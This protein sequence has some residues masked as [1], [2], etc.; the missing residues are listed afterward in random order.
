MNHENFCFR[1]AAATQGLFLNYC[2]EHQ[3]T[4]DVFYLSDE[5]QE[6]RIRVRDFNIS[7]VPTFKIV[8]MQLMHGLLQ[9]LYLRCGSWLRP[10]Q[11]RHRKCQ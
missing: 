3:T 7:S 1:P 11:F 9:R 6:K 10:E 4:P 2:F 8:L 5:V